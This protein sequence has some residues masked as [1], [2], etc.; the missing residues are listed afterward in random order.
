M[1]AAWERQAAWLAA[2]QTELIA[3]FAGQVRA[4]Y[5]QARRE[6]E[7]RGLP[8]SF[9]DQTIENDIEAEVGTALRL[10][11]STAGARV[12]TAEALATRLPATQTALAEG[13]I[14]YWHAVTMVRQT[15]HL[16]D[17]DAR[18]VEREVLP[19]AF[20]DTVGGLRRRLRKACMAASP[21]DTS[22]RAR[23]GHARA[24]GDLAT[25]RGRDGDPASNRPGAVFAGS[26]RRVGYHRGPVAGG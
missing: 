1:L 8:V 16:D 10:A 18:A 17:V 7:A 21:A 23:Q 4:E 24:D 26:V 14:S 5:E 19:H 11:S 2:R 9:S 3:T 22:A 20:R 6:Q 25:G 15:A 13:R 12:A